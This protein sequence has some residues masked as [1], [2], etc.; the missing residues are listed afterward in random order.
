[1]TSLSPTGLSIRSRVHLALVGDSRNYGDALIATTRENLQR[2][3]EGFTRSVAVNL[4]LMAVF[5]LLKQ[6]AIKRASIGPFEVENLSPIRY[7]LPA[8][9]AY[10]FY[11]MV[12]LIAQRSDVRMF[13]SSLLDELH[14]DV[15]NN[16]LE[17]LISIQSSSIFG[18]T[19]EYKSIRSKRIIGLFRLVPI[20]TILFG[21]LAFQVYA[22]WSQ[23][24]TFGFKSI[25]VWLAAFFSAFFVIYGLLI[26]FGIQS[27]LVFRGFGCGKGLGLGR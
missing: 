13:L 14:K 17:R 7:A 3:E 2:L 1:M 12:A 16:E 10:F 24:N 22:Y 23:V 25:L 9:I 18:R 5:Q 11:D 8:I 26:I 15:R 19:Y 4:L 6:A 21:S 27:E 20:N